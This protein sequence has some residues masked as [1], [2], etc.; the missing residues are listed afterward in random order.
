M[1]LPFRQCS[2]FCVLRN[3]YVVREKYT[4]PCAVKSSSLFMYTLQR[5]RVS[6]RNNRTSSSTVSR[7]LRYTLFIHFGERI[8]QKLD[9]GPTRQGVY[10]GPPLRQLTRAR[11]H[12]ISVCLNTQRRK[13]R[14]RRGKGML[15]VSPL[16]VK[17]TPPPLPAPLTKKSIQGR[18][19]IH[20]DTDLNSYPIHA[21]P[22]ASDG[23]IHGARG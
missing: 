23:E 16:Q 12:P 7:R 6:P 17:N 21:M 10:I 11:Q 13:P 8:I 2:L 3:I 19:K 9:L 15:T 14:L 22:P 1:N 18:H 4:S 5:R 20:T